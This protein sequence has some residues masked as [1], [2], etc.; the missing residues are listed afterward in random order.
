MEKL[1]QVRDGSLRHEA[2]APALKDGKTTP[3]LNP[4]P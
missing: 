4:C 3:L 1:V 2:Q